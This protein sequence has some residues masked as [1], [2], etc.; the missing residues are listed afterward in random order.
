MLAHGAPFITDED[1]NFAYE[2]GTRYRPLAPCYAWTNQDVQLQ[3]QT[4]ETL[5]EH[6]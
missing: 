1:F 5:A 6:L 3:E 2:D 4:L